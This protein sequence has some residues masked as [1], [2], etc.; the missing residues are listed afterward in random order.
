MHKIFD[1]VG[2]LIS[3]LGLAA[4]LTRTASGG[5]AD[6]GG[7]AVVSFLLNRRAAKLED[8]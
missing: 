2:V 8:T 3:L 6:C 4:M 7:G 1:N 5:G